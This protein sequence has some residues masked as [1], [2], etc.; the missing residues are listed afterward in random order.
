MMD[1]VMTYVKKC[2]SVIPFRAVYVECQDVP[3]LR[4]FY[5]KAGFKFYR[6]NSINELFIYI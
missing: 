3:Y 4:F 5:E 2:K 1:L 6:R